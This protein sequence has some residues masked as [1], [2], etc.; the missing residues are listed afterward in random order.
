MRKNHKPPVGKAALQAAIDALPFQQILEACDLIEAADDQAMV[1]DGP[2][3]ATWHC[4][5]RAEIQKVF[6]ALWGCRSAAE[7]A[8]D[9]L[10]AGVPARGR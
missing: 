5:N 7:L 3:P 9:I 8:R 6:S 2:V 1:T 10:M 4:M